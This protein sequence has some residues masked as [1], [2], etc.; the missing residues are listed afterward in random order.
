MEEE[1]TQEELRGY[2]KLVDDDNSGELEFGEFMILLA[3]F[4][5]SGSKFSKF[6]SMLDDMNSTPMAELG[7]QAK[8]RG[9]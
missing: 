2:V 1:V 4:K 6:N 9:L 3:H 8:K 7:L 5:K